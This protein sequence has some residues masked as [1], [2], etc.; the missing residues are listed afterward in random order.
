[1]T[2]ELLESHSD[3]SLERAGP[4]PPAFKIENIINPQ[5]VTL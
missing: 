2:E 1:M 3:E 4:Q 5:S